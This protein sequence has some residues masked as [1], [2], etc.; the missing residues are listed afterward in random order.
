M[1]LLRKLAGFEDVNKNDKPKI[2]KVKKSILMSD[3]NESA[4]FREE[5]RKDEDEKN[6]TKEKIENLLN[7]PSCLKE[8][9]NGH[10][11]TK[12]NMSKFK[13]HWLIIIVILI[14]LFGCFYW[15][16]WRPSQIAKLC[17]K[18][19]VEKA[20]LV[21]DGIQ[22]IKIYDAM[23]KACLREKGLK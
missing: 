13:K 7:Q 18:E 14:L 9:Q 8:K 2:K 1:S 10:D 11:I 16:Q 21:D 19:A 22:A 23:Y 6:Y 5:V 17:N 4:R 20:I 3:V 12:K 15:F